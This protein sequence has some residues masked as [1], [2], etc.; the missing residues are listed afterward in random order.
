MKYHGGSPMKLLWLSILL[1]YAPIGLSL[2]ESLQKDPLLI[3][4]TQPNQE[5]IDNEREGE[6]DLGI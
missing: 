4:I 3:P 6:D 2:S 5:S 1:L